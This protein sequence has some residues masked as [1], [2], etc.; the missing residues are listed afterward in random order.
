MPT[1]NTPHS[2]AW[3]AQVWISFAISIGTTA[4]GVAYLPVDPWMKAFLAM[5]LLFSVG[6]TLSLS[7]TIRDMHESLRLSSRV[8]EARVERLLAEHDPLK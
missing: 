1:N 6:S 4:I 2:G 3:V 5:G 7:K 8:E